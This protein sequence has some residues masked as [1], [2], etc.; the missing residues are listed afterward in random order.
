MVGT[1]KR[2]IFLALPCMCLTSQRH[3]D[4]SCC[5]SSRVG[6]EVNVFLVNLGHTNRWKSVCVGGGV[7]HREN[8]SNWNRKRLWL[9]QEYWFMWQFICI[10]IN[11]GFLLPHKLV[12]FHCLCTYIYLLEQT[13]KTICV[14]FLAQVLYWYCSIMKTVSHH[15]EKPVC[16]ES[17]TRHIMKSIPFWYLQH[18]SLCPGQPWSAMLP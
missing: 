5:S 18:T 13:T 11:L 3:G 17:R 9:N 7:K 12:I 4:I 10:G 2:H 8:E 15:P 1:S 14:G 6:T 16:P